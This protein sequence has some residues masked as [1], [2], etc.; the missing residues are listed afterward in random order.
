MVWGAHYFYTFP[1]ALSGKLKDERNGGGGG[2]G[3]GSGRTPLSIF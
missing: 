2:G 1:K 3:G